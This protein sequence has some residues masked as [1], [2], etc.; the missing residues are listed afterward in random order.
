VFGAF[1][2]AGAPSIK[3]F[4]VGLSVAIFVDAT[5]VRLVLVPVT[6]RQLGDWNWWLPRPLTRILRT[7]PARA[8]RRAA[9]AR[10]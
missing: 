5:I 2:L 8:A 3:A 4:G 1:A 10:S 6:M 7:P 9:A